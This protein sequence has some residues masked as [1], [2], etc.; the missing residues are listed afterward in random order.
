MYAA[1]V[2]RLLF[3]ICAFAF[4]LSVCRVCFR[5]AFVF[6]PFCRLSF[7]TFCHLCLR[8]SLSF[9]APQR[10]YWPCVISLLLLALQEIGHEISRSLVH[11]FMSHLVRF[12]SDLFFLHCLTR[13]FYSQSH[14]YNHCS[15]LLFVRKMCR[16]VCH[17]F[18]CF[19]WYHPSVLHLSLDVLFSVCVDFSLPYFSFSFFHFCYLLPLFVLFSSSSSSFSVVTPH[20]FS[21][22]QWVSLIAWRYYWSMAQ[23]ATR[24]TRWAIVCL[25]VYSICSSSEFSEC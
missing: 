24:Q 11:W 1:S 2:F 13:A 21:L 10:I 7:L 6:T 3:K 12:L 22:L 15:S 18:F 9:V 4:I 16:F 17:T 8:V 23:H 25:L 5:M 14:Y 19:L 20:S